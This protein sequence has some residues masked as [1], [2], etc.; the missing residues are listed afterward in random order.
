LGAL[1]LDEGFG[2]LDSEALDA[3][4]GVLE[5]IQTQGRMVGIITHVQALAERLPNRLIVEK[6]P[7]SSRVRW[8]TD[9]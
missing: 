8:E 9:V 7:V 2:T 6:G 4:A 1:F 3:V 5:T